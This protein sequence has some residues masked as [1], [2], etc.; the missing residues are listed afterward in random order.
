M[1]VSVTYQVKTL[2]AGGGMVGISFI[3]WWIGLGVVALVV[4]LVATILVLARRIGVQARTITED[5]DRARASTFGLWD[6]QKTNLALKAI[7]DD[8]QKA[9]SALGG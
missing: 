4:L 6:V 5:L 9:R 2:S 1:Y 7:L 3:G 8:A